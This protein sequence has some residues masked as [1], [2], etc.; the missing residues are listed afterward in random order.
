[1]VLPNWMSMKWA[2]VD[3]TATTIRGEE[4]GEGGVKIIRD[5]GGDDILFTIRNDKKVA[6]AC[7]CKIIPPAGTREDARLGTIGTWSLSLS[8]SIYSFELYALCLSLLVQ[9]HGHG[10]DRGRGTRWDSL[11]VGGFD[12]RVV[13]RVSS[14]GNWWRDRHAIVK[15]RGRNGKWL[16]TGNGGTV[17]KGGVIV[18]FELCARIG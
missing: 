6:G 5:E 18:L 7:G 12:R 13:R 14:R 11:N 8:I 3:C 16:R 17:R 9:D 10:G 4:L 2:R 15:V 1:M